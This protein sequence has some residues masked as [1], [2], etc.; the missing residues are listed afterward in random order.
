MHLEIHR[1]AVCDIDQ[2]HLPFFLLNEGNHSSNS[3]T[4]GRKEVP[5]LDRGLHQHQREID[6]ECVSIDGFAYRNRHKPQLIKIDVEGAE[7]EVLK[8]A[9]ETMKTH[10]PVLVVE[11]HSFALPDFGSSAEILETYILSFGYNKIMLATTAGKGGDYYH[12]VFVPA[13]N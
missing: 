12:A 11:V 8:G 10:R 6:V 3:L 9:A 1:Y 4:F 2:T 7:H 13:S 5:N